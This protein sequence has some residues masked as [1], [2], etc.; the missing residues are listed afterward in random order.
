VAHSTL[1]VTHDLAE[2]SNS[3]KITLSR[4]EV[5][6]RIPLRCSD[7]VQQLYI[8]KHED[9]RHEETISPLMVGSTRQPTRQ[10]HEY[11]FLFFI[12]SLNANFTGWCHRASLTFFLGRLP[13]FAETWCRTAGSSIH[14]VAVYKQEELTTP[15]LV[16]SPL[17]SVPRHT[18][19]GGQPRRRGWC[20]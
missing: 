6:E 5:K 1:I 10:N 20:Q 19:I 11:R 2:E 15:S 14:I 4:N 18:A 12:H 3:V 17:Q 7:V 9:V 8:I 13:A 16:R